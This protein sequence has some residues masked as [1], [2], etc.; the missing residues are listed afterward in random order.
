MKTGSPLLFFKENKWSIRN[1]KLNPCIYYT[2]SLPTKLSSPNIHV[3]VY[4]IK[5]HS[6]VWDKSEISWL[7]LS[8]EFIVV[9]KTGD[10]AVHCSCTLSHEFTRTAAVAVDWSSFWD[11]SRNVF[12][13]YLLFFLPRIDNFLD[14]ALHYIFYNRQQIVKKKTHIVRRKK[15]SLRPKL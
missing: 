6:Y 11:I 1:S 9:L 7:R 8:K 12:R 15:Y 4:L 5:L 13:G 14:L 10:P 2:M 3:I